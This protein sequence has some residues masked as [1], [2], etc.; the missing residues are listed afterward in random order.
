MKGVLNFLAVVFC[1]LLVISAFGNIVT[2]VV[3]WRGALVGLAIF[4][5]A[6]FRR[7]QKGRKAA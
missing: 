7:R 1:A 5:V 4:A 3:P 2:G 6:A